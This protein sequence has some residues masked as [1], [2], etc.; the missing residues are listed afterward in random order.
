MSCL[1]VLLLAVAVFGAVPVEAAA[2]TLRLDRVIFPS[3]ALGLALVPLD[4][5]VYDGI[6]NLPGGSSV[7]WKGISLV[8]EP[9]AVLGAAFGLAATGSEYG[10]DLAS[11]LVLSGV[12][13]LGLKSLTGMARPSTGVGP[14]M[15][16]P[17][18][19]DSYGAFPSGHT[20]SAFAAAAVTAHYYPDFA[21]WAYLAAAL[22][23]L[24]RI[25]VEAHWPSNVVVGAGLGCL[26]ARLVLD[27]K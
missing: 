12:V 17:T 18:I 2:S 21:E 16:G 14:I 24:S 1:A 9:A 13:T 15:T 4:Q 20:S 26:A 22:V 10:N 5:S 8:G 27:W 25:F 11:A 6:Q 19:H 3:L 7:V 23:G